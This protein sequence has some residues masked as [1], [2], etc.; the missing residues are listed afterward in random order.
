LVEKV[1]LKT[2]NQQLTTEIGKNLVPG[3]YFVKLKAGNKVWRKKV[4]KIR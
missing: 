1:Y 2:N 3:I 4:T